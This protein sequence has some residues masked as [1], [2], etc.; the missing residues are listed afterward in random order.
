[1]RVRVWVRVQVEVEGACIVPPVG[2]KVDRVM[3]GLRL[4]SGSGGAFRLRGSGLG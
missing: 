4:G 2:A 1:M 3:A